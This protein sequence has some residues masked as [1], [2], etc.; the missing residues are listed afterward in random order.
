LENSL[1]IFATE[2][3][4]FSLKQQKK[5]LQKFWQARL[6]LALS[7]EDYNKVFDPT[8][9]S[10]NLHD[11]KFNT[12][13]SALL[14]KAYKILAKKLSRF[15]GI[16]LQM[17]MLAEYFQEGFE[18]F[19]RGN[20]SSIPK[21]HFENI[22]LL[23]IYQLFIDVK[24]AI[25]FREKT[26]LEESFNPVIKKLFTKLL[27][28]LHRRLAFEFLFSASP[29]A[30]T[31]FY[32]EP[33]AKENF[34]SKKLPII[35]ELNRIGIIQSTNGNIDFIHRTFAEYFVT[36]LI[37]DRLKKKLRNP[38]YSTNFKE[39]MWKFLINQIFIKS[40]SRAIRNFFDHK[41][42]EDSELENLSTH[43][44]HHKVIGGLL[45]KNLESKVTGPLHV[46]S[47]EG[48]IK[49]FNFLLN[50]VKND[51]KRKMLK[52]II[53]AP[54]ED[55]STALH[56]AARSGHNEIV[57][58]LLVSAQSIPDNSE[59]FKKLVVAI[60]TNK[61]SALHLAT[62]KGHVQVVKLLLDS[63]NGF[64]ETL[65]ALVI[66]TQKDTLTA[67]HL[68]A[69]GG[70][71]AVVNQL[72]ESTEKYPGILKDMISKTDYSGRTAQ[73]YAKLCAHPDVADL[74]FKKQENI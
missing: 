67:L 65:Q 29:S 55:G 66:T 63:A 38:N 60:N 4:E 24:H 17:R 40:G 12:Y 27:T 11:P 57:Q 33:D 50:N 21:D 14:N 70:Y 6:R 32:P 8:D 47:E 46:A 71:V 45:L 16:P 58:Q 69:E 9:I 19:A 54:K 28:K 2:F 43:S 5:F 36:E 61:D 34:L 31:L 56:M 62:W 64:P 49:I 68:A 74:L 25:Y 39:S 7:L 51:V 23:D 10:Q 26:H 44:D 48:L 22:D 30:Y 37:I 35:N 1:L 52:K 42:G 3:E 73:R 53:L 13:A 41:L 72:L 20:D 18:S 59:T 15:M